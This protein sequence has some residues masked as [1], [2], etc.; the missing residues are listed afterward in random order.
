MAG[1]ASKVGSSVSLGH[2]LWNVLSAW[3]IKNSGYQRLGNVFQYVSV[4][5]LDS[6][7]TI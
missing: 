5:G 2:R 1:V 4:P 7:S 6:V 3:T